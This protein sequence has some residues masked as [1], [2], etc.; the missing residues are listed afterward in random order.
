MNKM[1][2]IS[3]DKIKKLKVWDN[4]IVTGIG[5]GKKWVYGMKI[6]QELGKNIFSNCD[7]IIYNLENNTIEYLWD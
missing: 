6:N 3:D 4:Q 1:E 5:K 7:M 2:K